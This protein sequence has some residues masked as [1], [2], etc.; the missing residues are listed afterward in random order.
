MPKKELSADLQNLE[1]IFRTQW[2]SFRSDVEHFVP[3]ALNAIEKE[4]IKA[5]KEIKEFFTK[6]IPSGFKSISTAF[7]KA[8]SKESMHKVLNSMKKFGEEVKT[9]FHDMPSNMKKF[10]DGVG[11]A[12]Q[13][14]G[15]WCD[16][17]IAKLSSLEVTISQK[18]S[19]K[20]EVSQ[21]SHVEKL[22]TQ[23][24]EEQK[25]SRRHSI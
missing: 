8:F 22:D 17:Q 9:F 11:K 10:F 20:K 5:N 15:K 6:T 21:I 16:K 12:F 18:H 7:E 13:K 4:G 2:L 25:I 1:K 23:R 3:V 14:F 19:A 24:T